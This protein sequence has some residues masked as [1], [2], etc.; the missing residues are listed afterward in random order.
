[1]GWAQRRANVKLQGNWRGEVESGGLWEE[2]TRV[3]LSME[4]CSEGVKVRVM[5]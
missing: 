2:D 4:Y 3:T 5:W 1:M